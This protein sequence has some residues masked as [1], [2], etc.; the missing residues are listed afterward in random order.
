MRTVLFV[1]QT[2]H[3]VGGVQ[4][5]IDSL[6]RRLPD[7]GWRVIGALAW[8]ARFHDPFEYRRHHPDLE[9]VLLDGRTGTGTGKRLALGSALSSV[10]PDV[11]VPVSLAEVFPVLA[12]AKAAGGGPR[13]VYGCYELGPPMLLDAARYSTFIDRGIGVSRLTSE[14]LVEVVGLPRS[15][16][17]HVPPGVE[18]PAPRTGGRGERLRIGYLG[19]LDPPKRPLDVLRLC[20]AL[21]AAGVGFE[22]T[23]VGRGEL[24]SELRRG[25][26]R[27]VRSGHAKILSSTT[28]TSLYRDVFPVLDVL[29]FFSESAEGL[30]SVLLE[31]MA[32]GVVPLSSVW[33]GLSEEG[34]IQ[35]GVNGL[36]FAPGRP[37][38]AVAALK[39]FWADPEGW[40]RL[41]EAAR[42]TVEER[43]TLPGMIQLWSRVLDTALEGP[44]AVG[45]PPMHGWGRDR[46][47]DLVGARLAEAGR[48]FLGRRGKH[49]DAEEWWFTASYGSPE[50]PDVESR[51]EAVRARLRASSAP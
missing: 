9:T 29:A 22:L 11:V 2:A 24:E 5:W 36:L 20:S 23:V 14:L 43:H 12:A 28:T 21:E 41:S 32:H 1:I 35:D 18:L 27:L 16:V 45:T 49:P 3:P 13:L 25:A 40:N 37:E 44:P 47:A 17:S 31:A 46:A 34:L 30:P 42:W 39:R 15:R 26:E 33:T 10:R 51:V 4:T 38:E 8:G 7:H 48:R 19:R 6:A 50:I